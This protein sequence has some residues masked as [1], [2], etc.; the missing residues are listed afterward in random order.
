MTEQVPA[1]RTGALGRERDQL[2]DRPPLELRLDARA[3]ALGAVGLAA[4]F[5]IPALRRADESL[6]FVLLPSA[7]EDQL[8]V[9]L[10]IF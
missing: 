9:S 3:L 10:L 8:G 2:A 1:H 4:G 6:H 5:L 7:G